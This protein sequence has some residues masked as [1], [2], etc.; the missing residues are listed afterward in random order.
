MSL[1]RID[2]G[3][4]NQRVSDSLKSDEFFPRFVFVSADHASSHATMSLPDR[5]EMLE[6]GMVPFRHRNGTPRHPLIFSR[7]THNA[8]LLRNSF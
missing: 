1:S 8:L 6:K 2:L 4:P 3:F 5:P 7:V